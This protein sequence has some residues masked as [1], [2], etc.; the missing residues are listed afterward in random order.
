MF[1]HVAIGLVICCLPGSAT[2]HPG[3]VDEDGCHKESRTGERHCHPERAKHAKRKPAYD[4]EHPPKPGE[5]GV[6]YGPLIGIVDGDTFKAKVQ[7]VVMKC[8]LEGVDAPEHDQPYGAI[9]TNVLR[10]I[11]GGRDLVLVFSDVDHYGRIVAQ[12]WVGNLDV[13]AEMVRRGAA[14]SESEYAPD[15]R[16]YLLEQEARDR[17]VG[18]WV[19]PLK[20]RVPPSAW[21]GEKR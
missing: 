14:W 13:N 2:A 4:S 21:R 19:L 12:A 11:I 6:F 15:E 18:L 17:K 20:D 8:R 7:G 5:E 9:S 10:E 16:L 3:G 1:R